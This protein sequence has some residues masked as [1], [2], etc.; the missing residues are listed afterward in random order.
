MKEAIAGLK[1]AV[2]KLVKEQAVFMA[3]EGW[4]LTLSTVKELGEQITALKSLI[5]PEIKDPAENP[6]ESRRL[7]FIDDEKIATQTAEAIR[8]MVREVATDVV[9]KLANAEL[10]RLTGKVD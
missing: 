2:E 10:R 9:G 5:K 6:P 8:S 7:E 3:P 1:T 4:P